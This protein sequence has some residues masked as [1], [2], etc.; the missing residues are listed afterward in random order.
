VEPLG[1][2]KD[3]LAMSVIEEAERPGKLKLRTA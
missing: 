3:R 2:V 1:S